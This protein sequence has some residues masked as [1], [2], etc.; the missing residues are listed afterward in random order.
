M[1]FNSPFRLYQALLIFF[2]V[3]LWVIVAAGAIEYYRWY[4]EFVPGLLIHGGIIIIS[5]SGTAVII[6]SL[7]FP[8]LLDTLS[9]KKSAWR[10]YLIAIVF[11]LVIW[12][13]DFWLQLF[14]FLDDGKKDGLEL[15]IEIKQFGALSIVIGSC[16]LAPVAEEIL[17][18]GIMLRGLLDSF[19]QVIAI[20]ISSLLFATIHFSLTDFVTLFCASAGY[21]LLTIRAHSLQ[22]AL[23]AHLI[24]NSIT[25]YY[26]ST[27]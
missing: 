4:L 23:L 9:L 18:R 14:F 21:A 10:Y 15:Q 3:S 17:F 26:L 5:I 2:L 1:V 19:N 6:K 8:I 12:L 27:L 20:L 24:N 22:P 7:H 16:L 13:A 25:V 11:A